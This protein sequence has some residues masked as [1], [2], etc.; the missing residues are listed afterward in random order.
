LTSF[1]ESAPDGRTRKSFTENYSDF[2]VGWRF[3]PNLLAEYVYSTGHAA[4]PRH[5]FL[6]RYTFKFER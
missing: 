6:L 3:K 4:A 5:V 2:G 1:G